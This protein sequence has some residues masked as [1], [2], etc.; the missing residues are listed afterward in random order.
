H[1]DCVI[2]GRSVDGASWLVHGPDGAQTVSVKGRIA[3][4]TMQFAVRAAICGLGIALIPSPLAASAV[5]AGQLQAVLREFEPPHGAL[6]AV[7]PS[8]RQMSAAVSSFVDFV[9]NRMA[10]LRSAD[11][12]ARDPLLVDIAAGI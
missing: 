7:Y 11:V 6:Y 10:W 8:N 2:S 9:A 3:V 1:H 4:N 12:Q 5:Q